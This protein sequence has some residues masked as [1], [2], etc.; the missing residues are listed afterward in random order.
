MREALNLEAQPRPGLGK[1][2]AYQLRQTG[3]IPAVIYGGK[4]KPEN[5][6]LN[7]RTFGKL[8]YTGTLMQT[9]LMLDVAGKKTRVIPRE[10]QVDP[11]TD[12]PIHVDFM[13]L[14]PGAR[15]RIAIPVRFKGHE[16]SPGVKV[17]GVL[18]IVT[19][20]VDLYCSADNIPDYIEGDLEGLAIGDSLHI[21][22]FAL[23]PGV[24][25]VIAR[26]FTVASIAPPTT[27]VEEVAATAATEAAAVEGAPAA[28]GAEGA[29]PAAG[30][31]PAG[32][33]A[34]AAGAAGAAAKGKAA[35]PA[36][37]KKK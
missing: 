17:G 15:I 35:A 19:H 9:V 6:T 27:Y 28:E 23:P 20:E 7:E 8:Y 12:R 3:N 2:A 26:N 11:V 32:G 34:P 13:R 22:D 1:G 30:A 36:A 33:A 14:E 5:L 24:K 37:E 29:A 10:V 25:P 31:A 18:N 16:N 4:G 21:Q